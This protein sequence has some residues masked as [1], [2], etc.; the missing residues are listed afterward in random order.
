VLQLFF[1]AVGAG[2]AVLLA[3]VAHIN[4]VPAALLDLALVGLKLVE[5]V[6]A[7]LAG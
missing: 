4:P 6:M 5:V 3:Q 7:V 1:G 2:V